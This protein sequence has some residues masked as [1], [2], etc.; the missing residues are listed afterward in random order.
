MLIISLILGALTVARLTR[1]VVTDRLTVAVRRAIVNKWGSGSLLAYLIHCPWC[2]SIW[3]AP[4]V[5]PWAVLF[6]N[7]WV[8]MALAI[9]PASYVAGLLSQAEED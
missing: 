3:I 7:R 9:L 8:I 1:L 2:M 5:M 4:L 6:P